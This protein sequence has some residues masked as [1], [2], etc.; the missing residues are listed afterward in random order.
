MAVLLMTD[1]AIAAEECSCLHDYKILGDILDNTINTGANAQALHDD[2]LSISNNLMDVKNMLMNITTS[3]QN[4][5]EHAVMQSTTLRELHISQY[6][7]ELQYKI[8]NTSAKIDDHFA[9][10]EQAMKL[11]NNNLRTIWYQI[12]ERIQAQFKNVENNLEDKLRDI[13]EQINAVVDSIEHTVKVIKRKIK[14]MAKN[15]DD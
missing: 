12:D 5:K 7:Q 1:L 14:K 6:M 10:V 11:V 4:M 15:F 3:T 2:T 9:A 8:E 13:Q